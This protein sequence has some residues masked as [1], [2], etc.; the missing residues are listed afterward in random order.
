MPVE[1]T[2]DADWLDTDQTSMTLLPGESAE[3]VVSLNEQAVLPHGEYRA[4][5]RFA[6]LG[7]GHTE[8]RNVLLRI[9]EDLSVTPMVGF[10]A[11]GRVDP[12]TQLPIIQP[13]HAL[14]SQERARAGQRRDRLAG[15]DRPS[16]GPGQRHEHGFRRLG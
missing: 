8:S 7:S 10:E 11:A 13:R 6:D 9:T 2:I 15:N 16:M 1:I 4:A 14:S 5:I 3:V 12:A